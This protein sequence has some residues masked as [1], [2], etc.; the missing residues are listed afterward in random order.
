[1]SLAV[2]LDRDGAN[3]AS[4]SGSGADSSNAAYLKQKL[5]YTPEGDKLMDADGETG[6]KAG[7]AQELTRKGHTACTA[8]AAASIAAG[9]DSLALWMQQNGQLAAGPGAALA[10]SA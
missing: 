6:S 10:A 4:T 2:T 7:I 3:E 8:T 1:V 9:H 5:V